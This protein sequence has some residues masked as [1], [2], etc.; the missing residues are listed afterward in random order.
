MQHD[1]CAD[2]LFDCPRTPAV[3]GNDIG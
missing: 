1:D 2:H 3:Y